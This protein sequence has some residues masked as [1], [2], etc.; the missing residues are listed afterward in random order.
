MSPVTL[1]M[2]LTR[3]PQPEAVTADVLGNNAPR[4]SDTGGRNTP[5]TGTS[6]D[7]TKFAVTA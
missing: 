4:Y 6:D 1:H 3:T 2:L 5:D 7:N